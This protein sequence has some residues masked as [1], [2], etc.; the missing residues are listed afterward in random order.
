MNGLLITLGRLPPFIATLADECSSRHGFDVH[1][2]KAISGFSEGFRSLA[3]GETLRVPT[4][5]I[6]IVVY[7]SPIWF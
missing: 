7:T 5:V 6:M 2:R 3:T 1:G 4:C